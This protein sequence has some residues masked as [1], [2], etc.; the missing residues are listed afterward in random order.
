M[1]TFE[2]FAHTA[3]LPRDAAGHVLY[4][5]PVGRWSPR[6]RGPWT[7]RTCRVTFDRRPDGLSE[8]ATPT[9]GECDDE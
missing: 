7:C 2:D 8:H 4:R 3:D 5:A 1:T 9:A 6:Y